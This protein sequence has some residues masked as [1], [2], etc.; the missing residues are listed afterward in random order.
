MYVVLTHSQNATNYS[1][2]TLTNGKL[3]GYHNI[4]KPSPY[5]GL[6][7]NSSHLPVFLNLSLAHFFQ[8]YPNYSK[9]S[10]KISQR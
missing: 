10:K 4:F 2:K 6:L 7:V 8:D 3:F 1:S 9:V 5:L